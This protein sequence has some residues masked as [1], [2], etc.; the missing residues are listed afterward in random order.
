MSKDAA[1]GTPTRGIGDYAV[2]RSV[3]TRWADT[4]IYGHVNNAVYTQ[5]FDTAINGWI[6]EETGFNPGAA[7]VI[8]VVVQFNCTYYREIGFPQTLTVG[9]RIASIGRTSVAYDLALL[10]EAGPDATPD[11]AA[12]AQWVHVYVDRSTRRPVEIPAPI[13]ALL[14]AHHSPDPRPPDDRR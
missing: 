5:L 7:P 6:I 11:V 9:V 2:T 4:D 3:S 12:Q 13:R 14:Q 1:R 10:T 8:G